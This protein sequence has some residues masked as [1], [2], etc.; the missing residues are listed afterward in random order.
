MTKKIGIIGFGNM[1]MVIGERL[2]PYSAKYQLVVFDKDSKKTEKIS[3]I[4]VAKNNLDILANV[5]TVILAIKPQ[6]FDATLNEI[7]GNV[8]NKLIISIAAG[9]STDYIEKILDEARVVRVMP[10]VP[11]RIGKGIS[12][13]C[14]GKFASE[15]DLNY[16]QEIFIYLGETMVLPESLMDAATAI[17]GSGPGYFY[18]LLET[19]CIGSADIQELEKFALEYFIPHMTAAA[20]EAGFSEE[21]AKMLAAITAEGSVALLKSTK[22]LPKEL[23]L[24]V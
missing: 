4:S 6:D 1:G 2:K 15:D 19:R 5:E 20:K 11:A 12:C 16:A 10:N 3:G 8:K 7:K 24:Q 21:Q 14:K 13:L 9:I 23:V 17:S 18:D 22:L